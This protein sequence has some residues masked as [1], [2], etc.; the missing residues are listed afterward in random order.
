MDWIDRIGA[1]ASTEATSLWHRLWTLECS[2]WA[3]ID[4]NSGLRAH[5]YYTEDAV[6]D[7]GIPGERCEGQQAIADFYTVRREAA[8]HTTLMHIVHNFALV[9]WSAASARTRSIISIY[10]SEGAPPQ[11]CAHPVSISAS[12]NAYVATEGDVWKVSSRIHT[13]KFVDAAFLAQARDT[14]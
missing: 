11:A 3:D 10:V 6:Y 9:E 4:V 13:L 14:N 2:Y 7:I 1:A 12:D 5:E 8:A